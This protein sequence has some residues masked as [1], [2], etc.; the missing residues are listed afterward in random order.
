MNAVSMH[1]FRR[2]ALLPFR[3]AF[4]AFAFALFGLGGIVFGFFLTPWLKMAGG[5]PE[6]KK[7]LARRAVKRWF[8]LF[9]SVVTSLGLVRIEVK[10]PEAFQKKGAILAANHPSLIDIVCL[11]S[12]VP[13]ATTIV[14]ASLLKNW[15]TRAPILGAG[16]IP[17]DAGPEALGLL[18][19]ELSRGVSF[20]IFPEGTR[21]PI[22]LSE[23]PKMHR[24]TAQLAL[25]ANRPITPVRIS[26]HPR[27]LTKDAVWWRL[28]QEPMVLTFEALPEIDV[29]TF[30]KTYNQSFRRAAVELTNAVGRALFPHL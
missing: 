17:N 21:T 26:A 25:H 29:Q 1:A 13:E 8:G 3:L 19:A 24:G 23:I 18:E 30:Q 16:Y 7:S 20:V 5:T 22:Q 6:E 10:N 11:L 28:P 15:F 9:V 4:T 2:R 27:W 12:I 14:K